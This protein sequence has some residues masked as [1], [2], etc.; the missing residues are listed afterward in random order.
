[1]KPSY[2][3]TGTPVRGYSRITVLYRTAAAKR[4][5]NI[6][7]EAKATV[8]STQSQIILVFIWTA[9]YVAKYTSP[10]AFGRISVEGTVPRPK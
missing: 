8:P 1:M 10:G 9:Q 2:G 4:L 3:R 7:V 5:K 6:Y